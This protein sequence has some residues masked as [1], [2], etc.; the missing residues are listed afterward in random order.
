MNDINGFKKSLEEGLK[1]EDWKNDFPIE[2]FIERGEKLLK[3][4][5]G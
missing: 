2:F 4:I 1:E 5:R 3:N